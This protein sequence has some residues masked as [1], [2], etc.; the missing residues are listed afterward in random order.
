MNQQLNKRKKKEVFAEHGEEL[1]RFDNGNILY[2]LN[3]EYKSVTDKYLTLK[4]KN[5]K[6]KK[7]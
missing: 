2:L 6:E 4:D 7:K 5:L 1:H 3:S